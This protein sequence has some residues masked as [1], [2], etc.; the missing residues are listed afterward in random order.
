[1]K[2]IFVA[3]SIT[4]GVALLTISPSAAAPTSPVHVAQ[5]ATTSSATKVEWRY[6]YRHHHRERYWVRRMLRRQ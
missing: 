5:T 1:M 3:S 2:S 4:L 6:R